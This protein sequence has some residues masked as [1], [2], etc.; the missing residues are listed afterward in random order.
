MLVSRKNRPADSAALIHFLARKLATWFDIV[1]SCHQRFILV[2]R[3]RLG[4]VSLQPGAEK[5]IDSC[6]LSRSTPAGLGNCG[7]FY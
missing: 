5:L 3:Q 1:Q 4:D 2:S 6:I 7:F